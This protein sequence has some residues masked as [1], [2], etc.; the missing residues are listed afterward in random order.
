M[1]IKNFL[2]KKESSLNKP[3]KKDIIKSKMFNIVIVS[4]KKGQEIPLHPE[5]YAVFFLV[6]EGS[7][8]FTSESGKFNM[9]KNDGLFVKENEIRGIKCFED[10]IILGVQ[11]GH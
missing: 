3:T 10:L 5:P 2:E 8:I 4:L 1:F 9:K 11:D 7:G 6:L